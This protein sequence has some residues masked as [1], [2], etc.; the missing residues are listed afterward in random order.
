M[1]GTR[2]A[3]AVYYSKCGLARETL[4][5]RTAWHHCYLLGSR[6]VASAPFSS[7][8]SRAVVVALLKSSLVCSCASWLEW[9]YAGWG[10]LRL[11][12]YFRA[13]STHLFLNGDTSRD[14][15]TNIHRLIHTD[16][17]KTPVLA[18]VHWLFICI[19]YVRFFRG[20]EYA[21]SL[22][23][24]LL[25]VKPKND[26]ATDFALKQCVAHFFTWSSALQKLR[27]YAAMG[28]E[29]SRLRARWVYCWVYTQSRRNFWGP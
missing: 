3:K 7:S 13:I 17:L 5:S 29:M 8:I 26:F 4:G 19:S 10:V 15:K 6:A 28:E 14:I 25:T 24:Y 2:V 11:C 20:P 1:L 16:I 27:V 22:G 21:R 18:K 23:L 9:S 12:P